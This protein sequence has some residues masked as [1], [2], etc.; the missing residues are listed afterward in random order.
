VAT[1]RRQAAHHAPQPAYVLHHHDWSE[2]SL[3]VE[4]FTREQGRVVAVAKG[5]K[6]PHSQLRAVL[7]P[8]QRIAVNLNLPRKL[9]AGS[10]T[11]SG[12]AEGGEV[13]LLR[14]AEW[15]GGTALP[16]GAALMSG[17]YMNELLLRALARHDP[18]PE[19]WDAYAA[20]LPLLDAGDPADDDGLDAPPI[21]VVQRLR[22]RPPRYA[23]A[24]SVAGADPAA[25]LAAALRAFELCLL[26]TTGLLPE[27]D[28]VTL[29]QARLDADD[30]AASYQLRAEAG[31]VDA[32]HLREDAGP[33]TSGLSAAQCLAIEAALQAD[34]IL[35]LQAA[36]LHGAAELKQQLR[37]TL[38]Y[39]FGERALRTRQV[40]QGIHQLLGG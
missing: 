5:A 28:R 23:A 18:H 39:H 27:F 37:R 26:R 30:R 8:L 10:G 9:K 3:I 7:L 20:T 15:A 17:F 25:R 14:G 29:T 34:D 22:E 21:Q 12:A 24:A 13:Q 31:L 32:R 38:H 11:P 2:S 33:D 35:A 4:L 16:S 19:L 1:T 6:R 36:C 40:M